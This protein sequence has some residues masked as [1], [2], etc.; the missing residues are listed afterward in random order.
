MSQVSGPTEPLFGPNL[1]YVEDRDDY[2]LMQYD[3]YG[4][5]PVDELEYESANF[6]PDESWWDGGEDELWVRRNEAPW[7]GGEFDGEFMSSHSPAEGLAEH[8]F[9]AIEDDYDFDWFL[10]REPDWVPDPADYGALSSSSEP[11][12]LF[13]RVEVYSVD[14]V[15]DG[16]DDLWI[17]HA[18]SVDGVD[19]VA[20]RLLRQLVEAHR[21]LVGEQNPEG[22]RARRYGSSQEDIIRSVHDPDPDIPF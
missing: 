17:G 16:I 3:D 22:V 2:E 7:D 11:P 18:R 13:L 9:A 21:I 10:N 12:T 6:Q 8:F 15:V 20:N 14:G 1:G 19:A 4:P 5:D